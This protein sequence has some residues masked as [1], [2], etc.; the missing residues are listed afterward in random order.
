MNQ[1][2]SRRKWLLP[3]GALAVCAVG[4][5]A[6]VS[7]NPVSNPQAVHDALQR[8]DQREQSVSSKDNGVNLP[9]FKSLWYASGTSSKEGAALEAALEGLKPYAVIG[10]AKPVNLAARLR[11]KDPGLLQA[12]AAFQLQVPAV[13]KLLAAPLFV[14]AADKNQNE[15]RDFF[16]LLIRGLDT[17]SRALFLTARLQ[18]SVGVNVQTLRWLRRLTYGGTIWQAQLGIGGFRNTLD[19]LQEKL[20]TGVLPPAL[21]DSV[22]VDLTGDFSP[23]TPLVV[24]LETE[25]YAMHQRI[26]HAGAYQVGKVL[27]QSGESRLGAADRLKLWFPG[28]FARELR[29]YDNVML[30]LIDLARGDFKEPAFRALVPVRPMPSLSGTEGVLVDL[31]VPPDLSDF[32]QSIEVVD[33]RISALQ[34]LSALEAFQDRHH[35]MPSGKESF[36]I[37]QAPRNRLSSDHQFTYIPGIGQKPTQ[38]SIPVDGDHDRPGARLS[39]FEKQLLP[40]SPR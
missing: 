30:G 29:K 40:P 32:A 36:Q 31:T 8:A 20:S 28:V 25:L 16:Q 34:V 37:T 22:V 1:P 27:A 17:Y 5:S 3:V 6:W 35:H 38:L 2:T 7:G 19:S 26:A 33:S 4:F 12:L 24:P 15:D 10:P 23:D 18:E 14:W 11:Q 21:L 39:P 9:E 13:N